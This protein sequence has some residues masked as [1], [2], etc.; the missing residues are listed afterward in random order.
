[1]GCDGRG[2]RRVERAIFPGAT[3]RT[4]CRTCGGSGAPAP[5]ILLAA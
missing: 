2:W 1:V 3:Y 5:A 4:T